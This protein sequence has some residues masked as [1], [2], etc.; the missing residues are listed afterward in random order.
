MAKQ[1]IKSKPVDAVPA[2][3]AFI[4]S[5]PTP[6]HAVK[7]LKSLLAA[8][9]FVAAGGDQAREAGQFWFTTNGSSLIAVSMKAPASAGFRIIGAHSDSP[10]L[11]VKPEATLVANGYVQLAVEVYGGVLLNPWFDRDLSLAGRVT[12]KTDSGALKTKLIDFK[13]PIA[14]IPSLAIHLDREANNGRKVNKQQHMPP[15]LCRLDDDEMDFAA[16]LLTQLKVEN[17]NDDSASVMAYELALYDTQAPQVV[18]LQEEF[19]ASARLDNLLSS[20]VAIYALLD[21]NADTNMVVVLNDHE[22][23]GSRSTSG[24]AGPFLQEV[25]RS[26][27]QDES[28]Y[29]QAMRRSMLIS[30]DNAHGVHPNFSDKHEPNHQ[31][32]INNGPVIKVNHNQRYATNSESLAIFADICQQNDIPYQQYVV[33]SDMSCGSTIGPITATELGIRTVDI[34]VPQLAMHSIREFAGA[35]DAGYLHQALAAFGNLAALPDMGD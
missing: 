28:E 11:K 21:H 16:M 20:F 2:L 26:R 12:V 17:A 13:R 7:E 34:G 29:R 1:A 15:I 35:K 32:L 33:R 6:F 4:H 23:V 30:A 24:A 3:L 10:C 27:C 9:G 18:G 19:I 14:T 5:A 25:L 22:E 31:P 8:N